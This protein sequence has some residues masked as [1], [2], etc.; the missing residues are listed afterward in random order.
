MSIPRP[1]YPRPDFVRSDWINLN[2]PWAFDFDDQDRGIRESWFQPRKFSKKIVVPFPFQSNLSGIGEKGFHDVFWYRRRIDVP[3]EWTRSGRILLHIGAFDYHGMLWINGAPAGGHK[4]GYTPWD[5]DI[6]ELFKKGKAD[7][8]IRGFDSQSKSQPRGKQHWEPESSGILYTRT[9]GAWQTIWMEHAPYCYIKSFHIVPAL[10]PDRLAISFN[11]WGKTPKAKISAVVYDREKEMVAGEARIDD[12]SASLELE[13]PNAKRWSPDDPFLYDLRFQL[14]SDNQLI[15]EVKSYAG[16]RTVGREGRQILLNGKPVRFKGVLDQ[17]FFPDGIYAAPT[18]AAIKRDVKLT[19]QLGFNGARKHQKVEDPLWYYWCDKLGLL[20]WGEIGNAWEFTPESCNA[21]ALEWQEAVRRDWNHPCII[22]WV[23]INESWGV[24][25]VKE[26]KEQQDFQAS[27]AKM[28][29]EL[30]P[31]RL[32]IDNSGWTHIDTDIIDLHPY[33]QDP[34]RMTSLLKELL[35]TGQVG[36][37][38]DFPVWAGEGKD[39]GQPI[40]ISEYGGIGLIVEKKEE[41]DW[42]YGNLA[43]TPEELVQ[44]FREL[45][46]AILANPDIAG[47]AYTQLTDVEQEMNGLLTYDRKPKAKTKEFANAQ[48]APEKPGK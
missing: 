24:P 36:D 31:T 13:I 15:D 42:G 7:I 40:V 39:E 11:L 47:Y 22:A 16:I 46:Q 19:K 35:T 18:E 23:P 14:Y 1:E 43:Q 45:T 37:L 29:R 5:V 34:E 30:D 6:T 10:N 21:L 28:T 4:G 44:R 3:A 12:C 32:A 8:V 2:G 20:V 41:K 17:G 9:S 48:T 25:E 26:K 27:M 38:Y 33:T